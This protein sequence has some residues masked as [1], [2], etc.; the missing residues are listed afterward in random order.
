MTVTHVG[1]TQKYVAG[2]DL[3]FAG[4]SRSSTQAA[5]KAGT[6]SKSGKQAASGKKRAGAKKG[7][8]KK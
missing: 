6:K 4:K 1:A 3:A 7:K 8:G 5:T 2:W